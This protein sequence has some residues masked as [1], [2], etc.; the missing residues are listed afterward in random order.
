M[1]IE[2]SALNDVTGEITLNVEEKD[3]ADRVKKQLKEVGKKHAEP[4]FRPGHVPAG[5]IEKKYGKAIRYDEINKLVGEAVY[6][7]I[8]EN[9]IEVLGNPIPDINNRIDDDLKDFTLKF[10][11]GVAPAIEVKLDKSIHVPYYDIQVTDEMIDRQDENMRKRFGKQEPGDEVDATAL[12]KGVITELNEDGTVKEGGIVVENGIVA[13]Q[14][15]KDEN[16]KNIFLGKHP[17]DV[18]VFNPAATCDA[19]PTEMSSMLNIDKAHTEQH[20]GDFRFEIKEIIVLKPAELGEEYYKDAFGDSVKD[21]KQYREAVKNMIKQSLVADQNYR[22]TIDAEK[23]IKDSVGEIALPDDILKDFLISQ[24]EKLTAE[25]IEEE[26]PEIRRQLVW[27]IEKQKMIDQLEIKVDKED[28][29]NSAR[30]MA[31]SQFA[32]YGM[33]NVPEES[34]DRYANEILKDEKAS[35]S[36]YRQTLDMKLFNALRA[37]LAIDEKPVSVEEFNALFREED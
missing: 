6:D 17:G 12:V 26:Y 35:N 8:R 36:I 4:G 24:N 7:Y 20:K 14:Y 21:E 15:F 18:V 16:Q 11:V 5:L 25:N 3:Y 30:M 9:N 31:R 23:A 37:T 19:N 28:M 13:P 34:L 27:D 32:Q 1:K 33:T 29:N 10:K 2:Y 22:F